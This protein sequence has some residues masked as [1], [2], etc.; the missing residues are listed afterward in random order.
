MSV[1]TFSESALGILPKDETK[2]ILTNKVNSSLLLGCAEM[3]SNYI[4]L[5]NCTTAVFFRVWAQQ[6]Q[7]QVKEH[8]NML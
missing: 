8:K 1:N 3:N 4:R 2:Y 7:M 6:Q 5:S